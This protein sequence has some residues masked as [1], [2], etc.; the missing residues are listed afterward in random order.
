M[1][2]TQQILGIVIK[3]DGTLELSNGMKVSATAIQTVAQTLDQLGTKL[4]QTEAGQKEAGAAATG[5]ADK[6][7][8]AAQAARQEAAA[9]TEA[10]Q[11][12]NAAI[13]AQARFLATLRD[14]IAVQG[15]STEDILRY[16][17]AQAGIAD[18]AA[19]L[20]QQLQNQRTA[21]NSAA[22]AARAEEAA[23]REAAQAKRAAADAQDRFLASLREQSSLQ[24][25]S[26]ADVLRYRAGQ[27]GV[28]DQAEAY[29]RQIEQLE[30]GTQRLGV[31]AGQTQQ[32]LRMLPAQITDVTTSLM[33]GMPVWLVA[34]Q[35]GGQIKDSF[36]GIGPAFRSITGLVTPMVAGLA[37][38][39]TALATLYL[40]YE[41]GRSEQAEF[42]RQLLQTGNFAGVTAGQLSGMAETV[43]SSINSTQGSA[44]DVLA[45]AVGTGKI[46]ADSLGAV[47]SAAVAMNRAVGKDVNEAIDVFTRLAED[48]AKASAKLNESMNYLSASTYRRIRE[49][50]EQGRK[51]EAAA[52]AVQSASSVIIDR[53]QAVEG[54]ANVLV[55]A[56]RLLAIDAG[57]AWDVMA[58]IGRPATISEKLADAQASL[59]QRR[60]R[61]AS[62]GI[63]GGKATAD[64]EAQVV[65]LSRQLAR[66]QDAAW[67]EGDRARVAKAGITA[68]Q[69]VEAR[70]QSLLKGE[71]RIND[72]LEKER[73]RISAI[74]AADPNSP[75]LDPKK[76]AATE[77]AIRD[78]YKEKKAP[79]TK[80]YTDDAATRYLQTLRDQ[81]AAVLTQLVSQDQLTGAQKKQA[82]FAQQI[83]DLKEKKI[84]TADQKSLLANA[85]AI[86]FQLRENVLAEKLLTIKEAQA[87]KNKERADAMQ[88]AVQFAEGLNRTMESAQQGRSDQ[89]DR[90]LSVFGMGSEAREQMEST[91][92]I[93][94]E[95]QQLRSQWNKQ[96]ADQGILGTDTYQA[97]LQRIDAAQAAALQKH[98]EYFAEL[99][100]KQG[101]WANGAS[102]AFAN[103]LS[104]AQ[105]VAG[106]TKDLF[107]NAFKGMEDSLVSFTMTGKG[108]FSTLANS[109]IADLVRIQ[110]RAAM[111][112][113]IGGSGGL[114]KLLGGLLGSTASMYL[115]DMTGTSINS[116]YGTS[117]QAGLDS[118]IGSFKANAKGAV[119][120]S[121]SLSAYSGQIHSSPQFF[122]FAKGAGVFAEAGPE[123]IM[124]LAR[125]PGGELGVRATG[126]GGTALNLEVN[127]QNNGAPAKAS[128]E[129]SQKADGS[130]RV[131]VMLEQ[132]EDAI[133]EKVAF[134]SGTLSRS[135]ETRYGLRTAVS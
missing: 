119:Y 46:A 55:R 90:T 87:K 82:E 91:K 44:S 2:D 115:G 133:A 18:E 28:G 73:K 36:G 126:S 3:A 5:M 11:A 57:K 35:Q 59:Q 15:K 118:L 135:L 70:R 56:W 62:L 1:S 93:Y 68:A 23:Q 78:Q 19:P 104:S 6:M 52:L 112:S 77:A 27:L 60:E 129:Q 122:A 108:N 96:S 128:V 17:A 102:E 66:E 7:D 40:A 124:P 69:E 71:A 117:T 94:R 99:R 22:E 84:L 33:G 38:S 37:L 74:R 125:G 92:S 47:A 101:D 61:N 110:I 89:Y 9:H 4:E 25:K 51:E 42:N 88:K 123:A 39:A 95:F 106:Q 43:A 127:V 48:P 65:A 10:T 86:S 41:S 12:R 103:Y 24:G 114:G 50:E 109:I 131:D 85:D 76:I 83:A 100:S 63:A 14:Q 81:N 58:G 97:Q 130:F 45:A 105:N 54:Q 8:A 64:A 21:Q 67:A 111:T 72:E 13:D 107:S 120:Q 113:A 98:G 30:N 132:I 121:P 31:S 75:L 20:I 32:A 49:L 29:I 116:T 79:A 53:M 34:I 16:R 26:G 80:A 134:G